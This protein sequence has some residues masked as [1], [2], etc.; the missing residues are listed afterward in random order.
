MYIIKTTEIYND[1]IDNL[2]DSMSQKRIDARISRIMLGNFGDHKSVG[3]NVWELRMMFGAGFRIYYTIRGNEIV[4]LLC[5]GDKASKS[6]QNK[7]I[8]LAKYLAQRV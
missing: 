3:D 8:E 7:D 2:N 6:V 1:W 4:I 5:G